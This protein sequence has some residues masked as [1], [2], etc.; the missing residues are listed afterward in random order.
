MPKQKKE[1]GSLNGWRQIAD[2]LCQLI[3][4][5]ERE[6]HPAVQSVTI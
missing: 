4:V 3:S 1:P 2:F 5:A 6:E